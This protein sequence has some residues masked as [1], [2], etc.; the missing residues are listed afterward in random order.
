MEFFKHGVLK[1]SLIAIQNQNKKI[2]YFHKLHEH[3]TQTK[4]FVIMN[5]WDATSA[6]QMELEGAPAI[7]TTSVGMAATFGFADGEQLPF[8]IFLFMIQCI[9]KVITIPLS[10]DFEA[11]YGKTNQHICDN[12]EKLMHAGVV[13]INIEDCNADTGTLFDPLLQ[14]EKIRAI[15]EL[16]KQNNIPHFYVNA[17]TDTYWMK[18]KLPYETEEARFNDTLYRLQLYKEA[19]ADGIFIPGLTQLELVNRLKQNVNL[20]INIQN[21]PWTLQQAHD[22]GVSRISTGS[23]IYRLCIQNTLQVAS[24]ILKNPREDTLNMPVASLT[25][26][27]VDK[28]FT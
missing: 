20:P 4:P 13:G 16:A 27:D 7:A 24:D 22:S 1:P 14:V 8:E 19:G 25:Y 28:Y 26:H 9:M 15:K 23:N 11:G 3:E 17:R 18:E 21:G 2:E 6:K 12:I 10:V 5:C